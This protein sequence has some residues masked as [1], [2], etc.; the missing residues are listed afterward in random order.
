MLHSRQHEH[1][2]KH[3][4]E[5]RC[6]GRVDVIRVKIVDI[7]NMYREMR[8]HIHIFTNSSGTFDTLYVV[9]SLFSDTEQIVNK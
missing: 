6:R 5:N 3:K 8:S 4:F 7:T 9:R 2:G 1:S